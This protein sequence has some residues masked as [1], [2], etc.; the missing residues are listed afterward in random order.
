MKVQVGFPEQ[1]RGRRY[2]TCCVENGVPKR[3]QL[4]TGLADKGWKKNQMKSNFFSVT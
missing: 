1:K 4:S 3:A 2:T